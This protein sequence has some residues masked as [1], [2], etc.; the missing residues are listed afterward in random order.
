M[1]SALALQDVSRS[2]GS[3]YAPQVEVRIA[4][5]GLPRDV[6]RDVS[7]IT[8]RDKVD[9]IDGCELTVNNWDPARRAFKYIGSEGQSAPADDRSRLFE[10]C[11][12]QVEV[13]FGY[14]GTL[15]RMTVGTFTTMEPTFPASGAPTLQVRM[16]NQLHQLRRKKYDGNWHDKTDSE[17]AQNIATLRDPDLGNRKRFPLPIEIDEAAKAQEKPLFY[18]GQKSEFDVDFLWKRARLNGYV[19]LVREAETGKPRRLYFGPS[20]AASGPATYRLDWGKTLSDFKPT[21]T[22]ANQFRSVTVRGWDRATQKPIEEKVD[23]NDPQLAK[24]NRN[25]HELVMQCDPREDQVV[26]KPVFTRD[27][28]RRLARQLMLDQ[29]KKMVK[30]TG[31]T[32]GLPR[33]R[34]G[35]KLQIANIG[36][37]LSGTYFVTGTT[38][39]FSSSG[40]TTRFEARREDTG[41]ST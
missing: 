21:L 37:R 15:E 35:S 31:S 12:K 3:F 26:D 13:W 34:A 38:H 27:E 7:E 36:A 23:F 32:I 24:L 16:L 8:Y 18:V 2:S 41:G 28:A 39:T 9:E 5:A 20:D 1:S 22:T 4:G 30:A 19:V 10:P 11:N 6:L 14:A 29:H 17:I 33:L 40:Y 25:L